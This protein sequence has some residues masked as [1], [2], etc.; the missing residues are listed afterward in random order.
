MGWALK[1]NSKEGISDIAYA[2]AADYFIKQRSM[3]P[4]RRAEPRAFSLMMEEMVDSSGKYKFK[5]PRLT[6]NNISLFF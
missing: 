5:V 3:N 1:K 4:P 2:E 6:D